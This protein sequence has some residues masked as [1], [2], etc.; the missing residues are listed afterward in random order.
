MGVKD[1]DVAGIYGNVAGWG[2][3]MNTNTGDVA[4]GNQNP[5]AGYKL[6]VQG[7]EYIN[8]VLVITGD[9]KIAGN[10][11]LGG[12]I[13]IGGTLGAP[14]EVYSDVP[15]TY[16]N[17][18]TYLQNQTASADGLS[19]RAHGSV[20]AEFFAA[21]SDARLKNI[22][23]GSNSTKDLEII[24]ALQITDY[25][26][27][28]NI[29]YGNKFFKK[30]IAQEVEKVYPQ[31][32]SATVGY[33]PNVY[34]VPG[35]IEK[36]AKGYLLSFTNKHNLSKGAKKI[37]LMVGSE[38]K[39]FPIVSIPS[40]NQVLI[41]AADLKIDKVFVYGEVIN[42]FRNIDYD[43]LVTLNISATQ[44]LSKLLKKQQAEIEAQNI[45]I[46]EL[47][48]AIKALKNKDTL[49]SKN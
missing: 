18:W 19:I 10:L 1:V 33:I 42:D 29:K 34:A 28:D 41:N 14:L 9:A 40:E 11:L 43:G 15:G 44:E 16:H 36:T 31:V 35:K 46:A 23:G 45:K 39:Q 5:M 21:T 25:T 38:T 30:V 13:G 3:V 7:N 8:G 27:K 22:M 20:V 49:L 24:N 2:L 48:E 12:K 17:N 4:V 47:T 32:V 26:M 37:Q 6:S